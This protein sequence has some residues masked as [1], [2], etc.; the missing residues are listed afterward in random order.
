[1]TSLAIY[2]SYGA[3]LMTLLAVPACLVAQLLS[4]RTAFCDVKFRM[5]P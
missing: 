5:G 2:A 4:P 3:L 1:M